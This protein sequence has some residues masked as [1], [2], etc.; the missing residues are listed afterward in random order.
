[1]N[2][3]KSDIG[4]PDKKLAAVCGL[5]CPSCSLFIG[6]KEDPERLKMMAARLQISVEELECHGCRSEKRGIFC[7]NQCKMTKCNA[8]KGIDFC[9]ECS[10]YPCEELKVFQA[11]LPH[12]IE[13]WESQERIKEVGYEKWYEEKIEHYSC[14]ECCTINSAYDINCRKCGTNP[15]CSFVDL[16]KDDIINSSSKLKL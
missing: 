1:M 12:R 5:F 6:T 8:E 4:N 13:L 10:E 9:V 7:R 2:K 15:G 16:H 14:P 11:Q 3:G